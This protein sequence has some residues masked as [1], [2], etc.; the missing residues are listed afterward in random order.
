MGGLSNKQFVASSFTSRLHN[1]FKL[2]FLL[3]AAFAPSR[4]LAA[5]ISWTGAASDGNWF[6]AANWSPAQVPTSVDDVTI[7]TN[8]IVS[9]TGTIAVNFN[10][11]ALGDSVGNASPNLEV[12]APVSAGSLTVFANAVFQQQSAQT[13]NFVS[14]LVEPGG[15]MTHAANASSRVT[16]LDLNVS[17]DFTLQA[18]ASITV[19]GLGYAGGK[20]DSNGSGPGGGGWQGGNAIGTGSG[21]GEGGAHGG[22]GGGA[23]SGPAGGTAYDSL[24]N[25]TDLGSGGGGS[26]SGCLNNLPYIGGAGGG[27]ILISVTGTFN[28]GGTISADGS[29]G[30][31]A[32]GYGSGGGAGGSINIIANNLAGVGTAHAN[33]GAGGF[34]AGGGGGGRVAISVSGSNSSALNIHASA[35]SPGYGGTGSPPGF[36]GGAGVVALRMPNDV[37]Y[38]LVIGDVGVIA[39]STTPVN[40]TSLAF[41][42]VTLDNCIVVFDTTSAINTNSLIAMGL[43]NL[44]ADGIAFGSGSV[45]IQSG[46]NLSLNAQSTSGGNL[47]VD[48]SAA[49]VQ[50]NT[51][52]LNF[53]SIM[54]EPGGLL[55]HAVNGNFRTAILDLNVS[56]DFALQAGASITAD[57]LGYYGNYSGPGNGP[58]GGA[59]GDFLDGSGGGHGGNGG[60]SANGLIGGSSYDSITNPTD[61]G[62]AGGGV[63]NG[64]T[65]AGGFGGGAILLSVGGSMTIDGIITADG[66]SGLTQSCGYGRGGGAGGSINISANIL[67]GNGLVHANGGSGGGIVSGGGG[68][69][70]RIALTISG[71]NN[72]NLTIHAAAGFGA[73]GGNKSGGAGTVAFR[74]PGDTSY[75]LSIGDVGVIAQSTTPIYGQT[76]SFSTIS[77]LTSIVHFDPGSLVSAGSLVTL[78]SANVTATNMVF[79]AGGI[80]IKTGGALILNAQA[81]SGGPLLVENNGAF[82]QNSLA[83]FGFTSVLVEAGGLVTHAANSTS[84]QSILNLNVSG[85][86][87]LEAGG[88]ITVDGMGYA[89]G[90]QQQNGFGPG[91]GSYDSDGNGGGG[92]HGGIGGPTGS[93]SGEGLLYDSIADPDELGSGGAGDVSNCGNTALGGAGGGE[94]RI[95]VGG[96]FNI[97]GI[98]SAN[99]FPGNAGCG[100]ETGGGAGGTIN[101]AAN[102][103]AGVG[104]IHA[105]GGAG[106]PVNG[107]GGGGGRIVLL[108][109]LG[110]F[111][112][113]ITAAAGAGPQGAGIGSV[114]KNGVI[115]QSVLLSS[116]DPASLAQTIEQVAPTPTNVSANL[117]EQDGSVASAISTGSALATFTFPSFK[118]TRIIGSP[119][120]D[121]GFITGSWTAVISNFPSEGS[122]RGVVFRNSTSAP[123]S[124]KGSM[125]GSIRGTVDGTLTESSPGNGIFDLWNLHVKFNQITDQSL[126]GDLYINGSAAYSTSQQFSNTPLNILQTAV[127]GAMT[128]PYSGN[129]NATVTRVRVDDTSNPHNG[130]GFA[131]ISFESPT[132]GGVA[133]G[134]S[135]TIFNQFTRL[136]GISDTPLQGLLTGILNESASPRTLLSWIELPNISLTTTGQIVVKVTGNMQGVSPGEIISYGIEILN[137]SFQAENNIS[138][139]ASYPDRT[140][141]IAASPGYSLYKLGHFIG[142]AYEPKTFLRWD[143]NIPPRSVLLLNY[144]GQIRLTV[145][146]DELLG[147]HV[148]VVSQ[149]NAQDILGKFAN[150]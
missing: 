10:S 68:G 150:P 2:G 111:S 41:S 90:A 145:T 66:I 94:A 59:E 88:N 19:D 77:L 92:G 27:A 102:S 104:A 147:G 40:G 131:N 32:C 114:V 16:V 115:V 65:S 79:G 5:S 124:I 144:E 43:I 100:L 141:F 36:S 101:I 51:A 109:A 24:M 99:G 106:A 71:S 112:G 143:V 95:F 116:S 73:N 81:A 56:G 3:I 83:N 14:V 11:L 87:D 42:T 58:G 110:N 29:T 89:G 78:A 122:F 37:N 33:G 47:L 103:I 142:S 6:N 23:A 105:D 22:D 8:G 85:D 9:A 149:A 132:G 35:G 63:G 50:M 97:N 135:Q 12:S 75:S 69:G 113:A 76:L 67:T 130:E 28:L 84:R 49:F 38:S 52:Q 46:G 64:C 17:G 72:A 20:Y 13:L 7:D 136:S 34:Q 60:N 4:A 148:F 62:S 54:V 121:S 127:S 134:Y 137:G 1:F 91:G 30:L 55:T 70:G 146:P 53:A 80:D 119:F 140:D 108:D 128:G 45:E 107:G 61:L 129:I 26:A 139:I 96:T 120:P 82:I 126:S 98:I 125:T 25:P 44:T 133:W 138:I 21:F 31:S 93:G 57:G 18:G 118:M 86:F 74:M 15:V 123:L 39:Q 48:S 117:L